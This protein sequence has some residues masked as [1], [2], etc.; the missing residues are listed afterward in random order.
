MACLIL[1]A[2]ILI[3]LRLVGAQIWIRGQL[4]GAWIVQRGLEEKLKLNKESPRLRDGSNLHVTDCG[5]IQTHNLRMRKIAALFFELHSRRK[6]INN[7]K[8]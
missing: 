4:I 8:Y 5:G 3:S 1:R 7:F 6:I 2:L